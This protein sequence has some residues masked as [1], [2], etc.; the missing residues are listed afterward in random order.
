[1][2]YR[3]YA[4]IYYYYIYSGSLNIN[5]VNRGISIGTV[6]SIIEGESISRDIEEV[7]SR[8]IRITTIR[9]LSIE[10]HMCL[11]DPLYPD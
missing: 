4:Y 9:Q 7:N 5:R 2:T 3:Y 6:R 1:M 10:F 11:R 8:S